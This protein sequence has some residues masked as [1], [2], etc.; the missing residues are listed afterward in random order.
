MVTQQ[1]REDH[2]G[3]AGIILGAGPGAESGDVV[4]FELGISDVA[5]LRA[6]DGRGIGALYGDGGP[7]AAIFFGQCDEGVEIDIT[8]GGECHIARA[9]TAVEVRFHLFARES[10]DGIFGSKDGIGH[11]MGFKMIGHD[12]LEE[13]MGGAIEIEGDF[14]EDDF[15]L[16]VEVFRAQGG[17]HHV[18][19]QLEG[20]LGEF[21]QNLGPVAGD[22]VAGERIVLRAHCIKFLINL[23]AVARRR[24]L[25]HHVFEEMGDAGKRGGFI[26]RAGLDHEAQRGG[27]RRRIDLGDDVEA[28]FQFGMFE[29]EHFFFSDRFFYH[30]V[31]E[32]RRRTEVFWR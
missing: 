29:S 6:E 12:R 8:G 16:H 27:V 13:D 18:G 7:M 22:L 30:R 15:F 28:V 11:G 32:K 3:V 4:A 9:V 31:T 17:A 19:E 21:R 1:N 25:E 2:R 5:A 20:A 14:L 23:L 26:A 10:P 24:A